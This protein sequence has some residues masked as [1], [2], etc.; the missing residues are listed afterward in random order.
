DYAALARGYGARGVRIES[1]AQLGPALAEALASPLP[2][3]IQ[4]AMEN[5]ATPTPGY[6]NIND[7]YRPGV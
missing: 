6:W 4:V 1:A 3:V 7:I 5:V 2:T